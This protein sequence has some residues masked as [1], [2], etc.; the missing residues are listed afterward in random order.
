MKEQGLFDSFEFIVQSYV[1]GG[2]RKDI[3]IYEFALNRIKKFKSKNKI[4]QKRRT[5]LKKIFE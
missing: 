1:K 3:N 4:E 2:M 5:K